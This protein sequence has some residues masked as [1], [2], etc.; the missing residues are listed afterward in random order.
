LC[1]VWKS[2]GREREERE[3]ER[4]MRKR[5]RE[6]EMTVYGRTLTALVVDSKRVL[7]YKVLLRAV[8]CVMLKKLVGVDLLSPGRQQQ[9]SRSGQ[10]RER[11]GGEREERGE[12]CHE[13]GIGRKRTRKV[14][15]QRWQ[16]REEEER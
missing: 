3:R 14:E 11:E 2:L 4:E 12:R 13:Q 9:T 15:T 8:E 10:E 7:I 16:R 6:R 1:L 5:E